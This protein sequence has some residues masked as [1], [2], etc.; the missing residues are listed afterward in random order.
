MELL[1]SCD[2]DFSY[3]HMD[4][5]LFTVQLGSLVSSG[6]NLGLGTYPIFD[7]DY[8]IPLNNKIIEHYWFREI[9]LETPQLFVRFLNRKMN[10]IMPYYNQLY[11]STLLKFDPL[12]NYNLTTKGD[13]T[14]QSDSSRDYER[15]ERA[16]TDASSTSGNDSHSTSRALISSTP[17]MQL[18]GHEDY[19]TSVTDTTSD[20]SSNGDSTQK[21]QADSYSKDATVSASKSTDSYLNTVTGISGIT[22]SSALMQFRDTFL[23]IDMLV[24]EDLAELF[25]GLYSCNYN[26]L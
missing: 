4:D 12:S 24:I 10:E 13:S 14:G 16:N 26:T 18:A 15:N 7:E 19:A 17:Q 22:S 3:D 5:A 21:S 20:S 9:G 23:N 2:F 6:Y 11:K 25:M 1:N 8:R